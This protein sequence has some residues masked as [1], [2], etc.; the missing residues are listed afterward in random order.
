M[1]K[2]FGWL[3]KWRHPFWWLPDVPSEQDEAYRRVWQHLRQVSEVTDGR[4]DS[5]EWRGREGDFV[6]CCLRVLEDATT[7]ALDQLRDVLRDFPY[8]RV[9]PPGFLH[10]TIQE[11]GFLTETPR[12]R[13]DIDQAWLEEFIAQSEMPISE[14]PPFNVVLSGANS[15]V[16][17]A[18]IDVH[19]HGWLSRM[20]GRLLDFVKVPPSTHYAYLPVV[21]IAHYTETAPIGSLVAELTPWRDQFFGE[22]RVD[23]IDVVKLQSGVAYPELEV[24]HQFQLGRAQPLIDMIQGG[25]TP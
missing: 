5:E 21:T 12:H 22:F 9:H 3:L 1:H 14:F 23:S 6:M 25:A 2:A 19:D 7:P 13:S 10:I 17:A 11:L 20:Q 16:D 24:I 15:F 8:A 4:H 18:F